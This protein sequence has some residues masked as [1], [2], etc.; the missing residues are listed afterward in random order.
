MPE[1][2]QRNNLAK[3]VEMIMVHGAVVNWPDKERALQ[4]EAL[5]TWV[6]IETLRA[7]S[8]D[9]EKIDPIPQDYKDD[10]YWR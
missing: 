9:L 1:H 10:K 7:K 3:A 2:K 8:D 5:K 6:K 4:V